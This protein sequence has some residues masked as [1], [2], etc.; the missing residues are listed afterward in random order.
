MS[1]LTLIFPNQLFKTQPAVKRGR[2][3]ILI[4][5]SLFFGDSRYPILFHKQKL[6]FHRASMKEYEALLLKQKHSII[7]IDY[8]KSHNIKDVLKKLFSQGFRHFHY[9][10]PVDD[11]LQKRINA[12]IKNHSC[13]HTIYENPMFLSSNEW[14]KDYFSKNKKLRMASFYAE[15]R[16]RLNI[17]VDKNQK[18]QG[19]KWSFDAENRKKLPR[20]H[21]VPNTL[22][23]KMTPLVTQAISYV[24]KKF[25]SNYG[26]LENTFYPTTHEQAD[27]WLNDF[28]EQRFL[29]FGDF[30]DAISIKHRILFHS[31]LSPVLNIGLI[32]PQE[33]IDKTLS[34][35]EIHSISL[36]SLEGFIRQII[37]W[38]EFMMAT[39]QQIGVQQRTSNFWNHHRDLPKSFYDG[40][41]GID[42][43]DHTIHAV[44]KYAYCHHIERLMVLGNFMLLCQFHP[45]QVY[46]WFMEM[47]IDAYDWVMVPNVYGMSQF[48]D[49]GLFTTKPYISSSNYIRK[50]SDYSAG[51]WTTTWDALFWNFIHI[52]RDFFTSQPRL[53]MMARQL[54]KM[55]KTKLSAHLQEAESF[56]GSL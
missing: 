27:K 53:S 43:I 3:I 34:Y 38:R 33:V 39:Y 51:K 10:D 32:T 36:N 14:L 24:N 8:N 46:N 17:L 48:A 6:M 12:F 52:H 20:N 2:T 26:D 19:G 44:L 45:N 13:R 21:P 18:P 15:Q 56:L 37:G 7:Y 54:E 1:E 11:I 41:T 5:D 55:D 49:G 28:L 22:Q 23:F 4:E 31:V 30:E 9:C 16:K 47:F 35:A 25:P 40:T 50:M 42:P 29:L